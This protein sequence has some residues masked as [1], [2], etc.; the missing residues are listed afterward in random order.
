MSPPFT[1]SADTLVI[2]VL[3]AASFTVAK[4][5]C[6]DV[7]NKSKCLRLYCGLRPGE[8]VAYEMRGMTPATTA[9]CLRHLT[10]FYLGAS[11][12]LFLCLSTNL[13]SQTKEKCS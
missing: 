3:A 6:H 13:F 10:T 4:T 7:S 11:V 1:I 8:K 9:T 2:I 12:S 5:R